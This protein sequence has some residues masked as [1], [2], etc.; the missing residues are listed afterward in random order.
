MCWRDFSMVS[1][2]VLWKVANLRVKSSSFNASNTFWWALETLKFA[3]LV[4]GLNWNVTGVVILLLLM[5]TALATSI[6]R[7]VVST[8][9][10]F[11]FT[12]NGVFNVTSVLG[13]LSLSF[14]LSWV[15]DCFF[16]SL[17]SVIGVVGFVVVFWT[18]FSFSLSWWI[19][20]VLGL[21]QGPFRLD[22]SS[23]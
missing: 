10:A 4:G 21:V 12:G 17:G 19:L 14:I 2:C 20:S 7:W 1:I 16:T 13:L 8:P 5:S 3:L 15:W 18:Y 22:I 9:F 11:L 23:S 6:V